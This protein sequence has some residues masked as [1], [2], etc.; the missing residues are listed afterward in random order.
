MADSSSLDQGARS[1]DDVG[2]VARIKQLTAVIAALTTLLAGVT[3]MVVAAKAGWSQVGPYFGNLVRHGEVAIPSKP[4]DRRVAAEAEEID[5]ALI[6]ALDSADTRQRRSARTTLA[7]AVAKAPPEQVDALIER[8]ATSP[9]YRT[10]LGIARALHTAPGG[11]S[12]RDPVAADVQLRTLMADTK[13]ATLRAELIG[14]I[15]G[16]RP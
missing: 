13:D 8:L 16:R 6:V 11:W 14:A 5:P 9:S 12:T 4:P 10:R 3:A 15:D 7:N 1:A 2:F